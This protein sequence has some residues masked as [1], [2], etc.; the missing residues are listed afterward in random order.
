M[1]EDWPDFDDE[2]D[3]GDEDWGPSRSAR[4]RDAKA[5][6]ALGERLIKLKQGEYDKL[7][8]PEALKDAVDA[9]RNMKAHGAIRRQRLLIGKIMRQIDASGIEQAVAAIDQAHLASARA[10]HSLEEWR[11]RLI[12]EGDSALDALLVEQPAADRQQLRQL[13]RQAQAEQK[14]GGAPK[15]ARKLFKLLRELFEA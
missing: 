15:A 3:D 7:E 8:L 1:S 12:A 9:A 13:I 4:K 10:H 5:L 14:S 2:H 11:E 6:Q